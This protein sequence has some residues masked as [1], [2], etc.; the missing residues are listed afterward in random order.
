MDD[1]PDNINEDT[2]IDDIPHSANETRQSIIQRLRDFFH[3]V[4]E[5]PEP[6]PVSKTGLD[7]DLDE[8]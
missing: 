1:E 6:R 2:P 4:A 7:D 8:E 3:P 5:D